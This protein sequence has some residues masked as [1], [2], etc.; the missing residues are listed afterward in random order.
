MTTLRVTP[1]PQRALVARGYPYCVA[2]AGAAAPERL[3]RLGDETNDLARPGASVLEALRREMREARASLRTAAA[4][5]RQELSPED[6][7][8]LA[9]LGYV[10]N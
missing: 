8:G 10:G 6:R 5:A 7:E 1:E 2:G 9:A 3:F 4:S